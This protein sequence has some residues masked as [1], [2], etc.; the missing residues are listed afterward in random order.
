MVKKFACG[1]ILT[2]ILA[3]FANFFT[4]N[5]I[6]ERFFILKKFFLLKKGP[7]VNPTRAKAHIVYRPLA[8]MAKI[9]TPPP[10]AQA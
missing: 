5:A 1:A 2:T 9:L 7:H 3:I 10:L 4:K 6:F 8:Q